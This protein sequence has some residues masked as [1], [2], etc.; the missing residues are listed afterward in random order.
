MATFN[1]KTR[2]KN[3]D[4]TNLKRDIMNNF[5]KDKKGKREYRDLLVFKSRMK[6]LVSFYKINK[7]LPK[8]RNDSKEGILT[9]WLKRYTQDSTK[10]D[11]KLV[12]IV[13][14]YIEGKEEGQNDFVNPLLYLTKEEK[15]KELEKY[16]ENNGFKPTSS[17]KSSNLDKAL[18]FFMR[19]DDPVYQR[20][21]KMLIEDVRTKKEIEEDIE[22]EEKLELYKIYCDK[23]NCIPSII[24]GGSKEEFLLKQWADRYLLL[25]EVKFNKKR[26]SD[27]KKILLKYI[28][29]MKSLNKLNIEEAF[30][31]KK[32]RLLKFIEENNGLI[33]S[34]RKYKNSN[35]EETLLS[36][37]VNEYRGSMPEIEDDKDYLRRRKEIENIIEGKIKITDKESIELYKKKK[38]LLKLFIEENNY[39]PIDKNKSK[40]EYKDPENLYSFF[41]SNIDNE[42]ISNID[43]E[44]ISKI[45]E[46]VPTYTIFM[47]TKKY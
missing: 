17:N 37:F 32:E 26:M 10:K 6:E 27:K 39:L 8:K 40:K 25:K 3:S 36:I 16:I 42:E 23:N 2:V 21:I 12:K 22:F 38:S 45:I 24:I 29:S 34:K 5:T 1:V 30:Q 13:R 43:N 7:V 47:K 31:K 46:G 11:P 14:T 41:H 19:I 4:N 15:F 9:S 20:R 18:C 44:E 35:T 28:G 33:P